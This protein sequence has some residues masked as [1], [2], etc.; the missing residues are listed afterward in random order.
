MKKYKQTVSKV[1]TITLTRLGLYHRTKYGLYEYCKTKWI[2]SECISYF[3]W[4]RF[5]ISV[6]QVTQK[7]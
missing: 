7:I 3:D 5:A 2:N 1:F 4:S 6:M